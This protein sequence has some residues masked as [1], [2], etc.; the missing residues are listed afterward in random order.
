MPGVGL[1]STASQ[2]L[3]HLLALLLLT[4]TLF[5]VL[6]GWC[7]LHP[8]MLSTL[9]APLGSPSVRSAQSVSQMQPALLETIP[10]R[11]ILSDPHHG[12]APGELSV[13]VIVVAQTTLLS[14]K[15]IKSAGAH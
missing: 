3:H 6:L 10:A 15:R 2:G 12:S 14:L 1:C 8:C 13:G 4:R 9:P 11:E 5:L 7:R